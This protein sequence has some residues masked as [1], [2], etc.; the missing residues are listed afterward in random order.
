MP[1]P[2][3]V[4][5]ETEALD[6]ARDFYRTHGGHAFAHLTLLGDKYLFY[7]PD[8]RALI[9]YGRTRNRLVARIDPARFADGLQRRRESCLDL[10]GIVNWHAN[11]LGRRFRLH[12]L[13]PPLLIGAGNGATLVYALLAQ[14][15][16]LTFAAAVSDPPG[17]ELSMPAPLCDVSGPP[18]AR[19]A[20]HLEPVTLAAPW[21]VAGDTG[22]DPLLAAARRRNPA[23]RV[24]VTRAPLARAALAVFT[25]LQTADHHAASIADLPIVELPAAHPTDTLAV[26]YSGDGGWRDIDRTLG[27]LLA[28][29][30]IA[31]VGVD[32][33]RYF[34]H[35]RS[36][37]ETAADLGRILDHY[38]TAWGSRR[39][40][41]IGYSFG[42]DIL[43]FAYNRLP[44]AQRARIATLALLAPERD[45]DFEVSISG[46]L[47]K[48]TQSARPIVPELLRIPPGK[49]LCV[50]GAQE[51]AETL[52]TAPGVDAI[53]RLQ[54]PGGHHFD[55][56]YDIIADAIRAHFQPPAG[57]RPPGPAPGSRT[58]APGTG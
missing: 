12:T 34:W 1:R 9:A 4:L 43:P 6:A 35:R 21:T 31:V 33:V 48:H 26:I 40:L 15:P 18:D 41:L 50:Y 3:L 11:Y 22:T 39:V 8:R 54:R 23:D 17:G 2:R 28:Q 14:A 45:A 58:G 16:P 55:R 56:R 42:A 51:A 38:Q 27:G 36:L 20:V 7:A 24:R 52:C 53:G 32:S 13:A 25:A 30:G 10:A 49:V 37:T 19:G 47:G 57:A 46:W 44:T 29:S 5:P